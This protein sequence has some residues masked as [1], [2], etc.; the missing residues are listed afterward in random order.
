MLYTCGPFPPPYDFFLKGSNNESS[1]PILTPT[2]CGLPHPAHRPPPTNP[3][4]FSRGRVPSLA[5]ACV[6]SLAATSGGRRRPTPGAQDSI[7]GTFAGETTE[8]PPTP[9]IS[10][11]GF[12]LGDHC[13]RPAPPGTPIPSLPFL[14]CETQHPNPSYI[15]I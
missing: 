7:F 9:Y 1:Q 2:F 13:R 11:P 4:A 3:R 15:R 8:R 5:C 12:H 14:L 6:L 10:C